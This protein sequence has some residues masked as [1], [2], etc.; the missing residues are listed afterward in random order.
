M[1]P[2]SLRTLAVTFHF[3][4]RHKNNE[5]QSTVSRGLKPRE[6]RVLNP[7]HRGFTCL[8]ETSNKGIP[9]TLIWRSYLKCMKFKR[10]IRWDDYRAWCLRYGVW[11]I[12]IY[13]Q[14]IYTPWRFCAIWKALIFLAISPSAVSIAVSLIDRLRQTMLRRCRLVGAISKVFCKNLTVSYSRFMTLYCYKQQT[15]PG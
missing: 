4:R 12:Y 11:C 9:K 1:T 3:M 13:I 5:R 7:R 15:G 6:T 14:A 8:N 2:Q 10:G